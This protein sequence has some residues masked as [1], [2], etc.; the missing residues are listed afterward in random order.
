MKRVSEHRPDVLKECLDE[1]LKMF[2]EGN[3]KIHI[4][5]VVAYMFTL[6]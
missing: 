4:H 3:L 1:V 2:K 5:K 6:N